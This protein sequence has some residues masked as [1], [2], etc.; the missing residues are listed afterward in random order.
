M[1]T[2]ALVNEKVETPCSN[3]Q[4]VANLRPIRQRPTW[5]FQTNQKPLSRV[6]E[7]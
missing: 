1:A 5:F 2:S 7:W 4:R 6:K 3:S